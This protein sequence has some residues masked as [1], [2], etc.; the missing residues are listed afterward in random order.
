MKGAIIGDIVGSVYEFD[1]IRTKD[2]PLFSFRFSV[3]SPLLFV[4]LRRSIALSPLDKAKEII[5]PSL[6]NISQKH[7][8]HG[9]ENTRTQVMAICS[10][11][12]FSPINHIRIIA[13]AMDLL[14]VLAL[15][16]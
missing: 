3:A 12:G 13:V 7:Y 2:F 15:W 10:L 1:N 9:E 5:Q 14:C 8:R 11:N 6:R 4:V 16:E